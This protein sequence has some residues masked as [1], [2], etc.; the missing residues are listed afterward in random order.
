[1]LLASALGL[2]K[3]VALAYT[4]PAQD[5]GQYVS[6]F[7]IATFASLFVSFGLTEKTVKEYPRRWVSGQQQLILK[8][9]AIIGRTL[10][11]RFLF[12]GVLILS[13]TLLG[14]ISIEP[15]VVIL[16][17]LLGLST[18]LL[19]LTA[20]LYRAVGSKIAL[21]NFTLLRSALTVCFALP[22]GSLLGWQGAIGGDIIG[23]LI[24]I[25]FAIWQIPRLYRNEASIFS[26]VGPTVSSE[27]GH[28]Q[29]YFANLAVAP[30]SMLDRAWISNSLGSASA[31]SFGLVMLIPQAVQ[32]LGNV[33]VQYI[34]P[35]IV[36]LVHL[37]E[38]GAD[39]QS[40]IRFNA[41]LL[42]IFSMTLT[43]AVLSAKRASYLDYLFAKFEI[44][45]TSLILAGVI[46]CGQ[47]YSLIEFHLI[48]RDRERDVLLASLV[49]GLI[50]I[51]SFTVASATHVSIEWFLAG[52]CV[53]R[54][55]QVWMLRRAYLR[56][57]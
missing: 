31:G 19:A 13:F 54:W 4:M 56:Y 9:A 18:G 22:A 46:A 42:A 10:A 50:F 51:A 38:Q 15:V 48:A 21:K 53:A 8:D 33:V 57:A 52:A 24:V 3:F 7:G 43:M 35:L 37:K 14:L 55:G 5:Y 16:T 36:K 11:L 6:Y 17:A 40:T 41:A 20:S 49:S 44:S 23:S 2:F 28:Y 34:G 29:I 32:L 25:I 45:D 39:R 26:T 30:Q 27:N 12:L 47:I 1:M